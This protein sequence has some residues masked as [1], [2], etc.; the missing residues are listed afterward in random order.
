MLNVCLWHSVMGKSTWFSLMKYKGFLILNQYI[1]A[2]SI[3]FSR[4]LTAAAG[5]QMEENCFM[6]FQNT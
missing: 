6:M 5:Y 4:V 2:G 1:K 3:C